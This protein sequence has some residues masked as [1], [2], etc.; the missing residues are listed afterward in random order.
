MTGQLVRYLARTLTT[1]LAVKTLNSEVIMTFLHR[2]QN[3]L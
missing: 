3:L 2:S 1:I